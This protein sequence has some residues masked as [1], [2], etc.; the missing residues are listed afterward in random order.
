[1]TRVMDF[2]WS[3]GIVPDHE[4]QYSYLDIFLKSFSQVMRYLAGNENTTI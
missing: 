2:D 3:L 1:M 4:E